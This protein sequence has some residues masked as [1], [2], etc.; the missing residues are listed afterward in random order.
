VDQRNFNVYALAQFQADCSPSC[1]AGSAPPISV[2]LTPASVTLTPAQTQTFTAT[3]ANTTNA[4]VTWSLSP[5]V[6]SISTAGLYTAPASITT[7]QTVTV[8]ATSVA[9]TA[10]SASA[11]VQLNLGA[12]TL[13]INAISIPFGNVVVNT[14]S[15]QELT[16]TSTGTAP[17]TVTAATLTG[18]GYTMSGG[19][20]FPATLN[21]TQSVTLNVVFDPTV[22]GPASGQLTITSNSSTNSTDVIP[23]S[24]T[25]ETA[26]Y[27]VSLSWD[28]PASSSDPVAGYNI[29]R[30]LSGSSAYELLNSSVDTATTYVD[31]TVQAGLTYDYIVESVDASGVE[32][33]PSNMIVVSIP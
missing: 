2:T 18:I 24:G 10:V 3:V 16:L 28:A 1:S 31:N 13:N 6:G 9:N 17:V 5:A 29:Y 11:T 7:A 19:V 27:A 12:P 20:A 23:L 8:T 25:G 4:A 14:T 33:A 22:T 26:S 15:T 30:S 32:S 21:P